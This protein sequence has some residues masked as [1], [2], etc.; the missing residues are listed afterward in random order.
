MRVAVISD[1]HGNLHA[2][3]AVLA[4]IAR[5][6][7]D[8]VWC[9]GDIVGYGARPNECCDV[10]RE[11]TQ[12]SLCGNHDLA[13]LGSIDIAAFSGDAGTA[14]RWTAGVLEASRRA[15]LSSLEPLA[16]RNDVDLFHASARD[17]VW[18]YVL[19]EHVA[20]LSLRETKA[21]VVL[22]GHS[23]VAL[24]LGWDG[25]GTEITGGVAPAGTELELR[26]RRLLLNPGSVG[27]PRDGDPRAAWLLLDLDAG[28]A[29]FHRVAYPIA[30]TQA[31]IR[32]AGLPDALAGR[33]EHGI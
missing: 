26:G 5:T 23:H 21:P 18:E 11:R 20:L 19:S 33:L 4:E 6:G 24:A 22:V 30:E 8:E 32:A 15:W 27:Q 12:L 3:D 10:V 13:V 29:A 17:P 9:L 2:L 28:R 7:V 16:Q 14:A 25:A 1:I 31:E